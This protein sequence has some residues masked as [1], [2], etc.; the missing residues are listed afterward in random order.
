MFVAVAAAL[1][2]AGAAG[3]AVPERLWGTYVGGEHSEDHVGV[4]VDEAGNIYLAGT[5]YSSTGIATP[6]AYKS[7]HESSDAFLMKFDP[8]GKRLWGTY[9]GGPGSENVYVAEARG[10]KVV[11]GGHTSSPTGLAT[12]GAFDTTRDNVTDGFV[13]CFT[14]A[15]VFEWGTYV[16]GELGVHEEDVVW[17][18]ALDAQGDVYVAGRTSGVAGIGSPGAHQPNFGGGPSDAYVL[19]LGAQG[20]RIWGTY[21]GGSGSDIGYGVAL[22]PDGVVYLGGQSS[23]D[24]SIATPGTFQPVKAAMG[25]GFIARLDDSGA[26]VWGTYFGGS[27][28]DVGG[29]VAAYPGGVVYAHSGRSTGQATPGVHQEQLGGDIDAVVG[30]FDAAGQRLWSTYIGGATGEMANDLAVGADGAIYVIGDTT[31]AAAIATPDAF[32]TALAGVIDVFAMRFDGAGKRV[33]GTY[34]GGPGGTTRFGRVARIAGGIVVAGDTS[35]LTGIA[36]PGAHKE[37]PADSDDFLVRFKDG[38]AGLPCAGP[39]SCDGALCVDGVCCDTACGGGDASDCQACSVAAGGATDGV[40]GPRGPGE[41]RPSAGACDAAEACDGASPTCPE[42]QAEVDGTPC[43]A[44]GICEAGVCTHGETG[45]G[46]SGGETTGAVGET[47]A[48]T[49]ATTTTSLSTSTSTSSA[50]ATEGSGASAPTGGPATGGISD[51]D[52]ASGSSSAPTGDAPPATTATGDTG[53]ASDSG[54]ATGGAPQGTDAGCGCTT[55]APSSLAI[56]LV[57]LT[58][59]RRRRAA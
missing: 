53:V 50:G 47:G 54:G 23:S 37:A 40:C 16:G 42:D 20:Q 6:G 8:A 10:G 41:C 52:S 13:A 11:F 44:D 3:A 58:L 59:R 2:W 18:L 24:T 56:G 17:A 35:A 21:Y 39:Q 30:R 33:W 51:G 45:P 28:H 26:R 27:E 49:T 19:R 55:T 25:D 57:L 43:E 46:T 38:D 34:Y 9:F 31:S 5:T 15:G 12:P 29:S 7:I 14:D 32:Q 48:T 4:A 22:G 1:A 36:T